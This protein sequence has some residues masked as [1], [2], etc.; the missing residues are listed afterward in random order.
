[1]LS[2]HVEQDFRIAL[3][4]RRMAT[5]KLATLAIN[6]IVLSMEFVNLSVTFR[7]ARLAQFQGRSKFVLPAMAIGL[8]KTTCVPLL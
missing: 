1:M 5:F 3:P 7:I 6:L 4:V 2:N 8:N